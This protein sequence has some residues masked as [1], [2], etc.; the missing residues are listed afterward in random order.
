M[1]FAPRF[2]PDGNKIIMS[3]SSGRRRV[4]RPI[5]GARPS[6]APDERFI[7]FRTADGRNVLRQPSLNEPAD[8]GGV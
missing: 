4:K 7:A 2:S 6:F 8:A 1:T 3:L 5:T